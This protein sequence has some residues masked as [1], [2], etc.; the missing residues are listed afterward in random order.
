MQAA[1]MTDKEGK[2]NEATYMVISAA[3]AAFRWSLEHRE[4]VIAVLFLPLP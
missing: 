4:V 2:K 1:I 3:L